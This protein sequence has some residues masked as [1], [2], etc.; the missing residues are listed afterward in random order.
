MIR[1]ILVPVDPSEYTRAAVAMACELAK[2]HNAEVTAIGIV[3]KPGIERSE[4]G[5]PIGAI[6][7]AEKAIEHKVDE[8]RRVIMGLFDEF[9]KTCDEA[10]VPHRE[11]EKV[12]DPEK[13]LMAES[14]YHDLLIVGLRS[15]LHFATEEHPEK[16]LDELLDATITPILAVPVELSELH[17]VLV[18]YDGSL[19]AARSLQRFA[20]LAVVPNLA[21]TV[22][23]VQD[24]EDEARELVTRAEEYLRVYGAKNVT[25]VYRKGDVIDTV[26]NEFID[27]VDTVVLGVH[28]RLPLVDFVVGS[29]TKHV[30]HRGDRAVFLGQ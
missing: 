4:G 13:L 17:H 21:I 11:T 20:H 14:R 18:A 30:I 9:R 2:K 22:L 24:D 6:Y 7:Y 16:N 10:G 15:S 8:A 28:S 27:K 26:E 29:L 3:D 23:S 5:A 25:T 1:R 12:G 19:P